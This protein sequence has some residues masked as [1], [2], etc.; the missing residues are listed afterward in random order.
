ML[1]TNVDCSLQD[2]GKIVNWLKDEHGI[3]S[4][5]DIV[6]NHTANESPWL[7]LHPESA[8]N[9]CNSPWFR[10]AFLLDRLLWHL[11]IDIEDGRWSNQGLVPE[12]NCEYHLDQVRTIFKREY[13]PMVNLEEFYMLDALQVIDECEV[14]MRQY[15]F[16][17]SNTIVIQR[18]NKTNQ[19]YS[20]IKV[21][22][23]THYRRFGSTIDFQN[24]IVM[25]MNEIEFV[26]S[27]NEIDAVNRWIDFA[28]SR[29]KEHLNRLNDEIKAQITDHLNNAVEN[30]IKGAR[31]ERLSPDG[32]KL[33]KISKKTPLATQ[34]FID[35]INAH[36]NK[37]KKSCVESISLL[38]YCFFSR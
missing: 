11:T 30:V 13:L 14:H 29:V 12:L 16:D 20:P 19:Q 24:A 35:E 10:P 28:I 22:Q 7:K 4:L 25:M 2:V 15:F 5:T 32:P 33:P 36:K 1:K 18:P 27:A 3:L 31:Y 23:D 38:F 17:P 34:Y 9:C 26:N 6:L 21:I 8:Y 37:G